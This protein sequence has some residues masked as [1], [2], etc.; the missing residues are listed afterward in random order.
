MSTAAAASDTMTLERL[1]SNRRLLPKIAWS[2]PFDA[3]LTSG[4]RVGPAVV[5]VTDARAVRVDAWGRPFRAARAVHRRMPARRARGPSRR[6]AD[7]RSGRLSVPG[8][9]LTA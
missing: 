6:P 1:T 9:C 5:D 2:S 4:A 3:Q 7:A 8:R